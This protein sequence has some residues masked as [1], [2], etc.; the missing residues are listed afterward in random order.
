[1]F[2]KI[3]TYTK[4]QLKTRFIAAIVL[5]VIVIAG[6]II[7]LYHYGFQLSLFMV[8]M[9]CLLSIPGG[10]ISFFGFFIDWKLIIRLLKNSFDCS[11][12]FFIPF[13][14]TYNFAK[15]MFVELA[16]GIKA[17]AHMNTLKQ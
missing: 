13:K 1:M 10:I 7:A 4:A 8:I 15:W 9:I 3:Y 5:T 11:H 16:I 14:L 12:V 2:D 6:G 17:I